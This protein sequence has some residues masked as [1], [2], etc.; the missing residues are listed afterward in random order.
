MDFVPRALAFGV[1]A[2]IV[3]TTAVLWG[4]WR[5]RDATPT[6]T[7]AIT[8]AC[9]L[10]VMFALAWIA[11]FGLPR[12]PPTSG[13]DWIL[14][15]ALAGGVVA[16]APVAWPARG[17]ALAALWLARACV[18]AGGM[19]LISRNRISNGWPQA[20]YLPTIAGFTLAGL[21]AWWGVTR[22]SRE[23]GPL[24]PILIVFAATFTSVVAAL[25]GNIHHAISP[26][27][28]CA[29]VGPGMLIA[30]VRPNFSWGEGAGLAASFLGVLWFFLSVL[31]ETPL[32]MSALCATSAIVIGVGTLGPLGQ[33]RGVKAWFI[34]GGLVAVPG[35]AAVIWALT[36]INPADY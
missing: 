35:L 33:L 34:R 12:I 25:T 22:V 7:R 1:A 6:P 20:E 3:V 2:P 13:A 5:R 26:A 21:G 11:G 18:L 17:L 36:T 9:V 32:L 14:H 29:V 10:V 4:V 30:F 23:A 16:I 31:G 8:T 28:L 24:P 19:Y 15:V 27:V